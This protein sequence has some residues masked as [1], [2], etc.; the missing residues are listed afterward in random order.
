VF[1]KDNPWKAGD[2]LVQKDLAQT[3]QLIHDKGEAG[4]YEGPVADKIVAEM[5]AGG[6]IISHQDLKDYDAKWRT[7]MIG[8]YKAYQV[9]SMPPPSS[10]G[11]ALLQ[12]LELVEPYP[13]AEM[14]F[15]SVPAVHLMCEAERRVYADRATH[16]GD[17]DFY[18]VPMNQLLNADY[19]KGRM[20]N[21]DEQ[22]ATPS[23]SILAGNFIPKESEETT[24]YS[25]IDNEGNAVSVTTTIN[26]GYG[27][28]TVVTGAGFILN[29]EMDDFSAK[30]GVPNFYGLVGNEANAIEPGKRMLSSMTPSILLKDGELYMVV[31]TPGGSTIITSVFQTIL[32]VI[33]FGMDVGDAVNANRFHHQWLPDA[34]ICEEGTFDADQSAQLK[35]LKHDIKER[36][37]IGRVE[38]IV[39]QK[40]GTWKGGA[41]RR[42]DDHAEGW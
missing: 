23:D 5:K 30:P 36:K 2:L 27:S 7:P 39:R 32:N 11:I 40:D 22:M 38:A 41:D 29:N 34:I 16:L 31:G 20:D 19:L 33:E 3:L 10:G 42:G 6:G 15:Q 12:L 1:V 14:G 13:L 28:K 21:F 8:D 24:H 9:I 35:A 26:S 4:F 25:I 18:P 37:S 17:N